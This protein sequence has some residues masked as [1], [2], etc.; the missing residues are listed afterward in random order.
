MVKQTLK[1]ALVSMA[2]FYFQP[3]FA[4]LPGFLHRRK[5]PRSEKFNLNGQGSITWMSFSTST[6]VN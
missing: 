6:I 5:R 1:V 2:L 4:G 3:G